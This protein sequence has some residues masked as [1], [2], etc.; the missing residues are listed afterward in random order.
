MFED[1]AISFNIAMMCFS[2][3]RMIMYLGSREFP[4]KVKLN[5][6][7]EDDP[8][9]YEVALAYTGAILQLSKYRVLSYLCVIWCRD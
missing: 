1:S 5:S 7:Y 3:F 4:T 2:A 8:K 6:K 9:I